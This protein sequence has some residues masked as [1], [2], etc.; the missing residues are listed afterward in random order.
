M[1]R[2]LLP[3]LLGRRVE[4]SPPVEEKAASL[5]QRQEPR[6]QILDVQDMTHARLLQLMGQL[7]RTDYT[8]GE[9]RRAAR[10]PLIAGIIRTILREVESH[11]LRVKEKDPTDD[12]TPKRMLE[13]VLASPNDVDRTF[14]VVI[15]GMMRDWLVVGRVPIE[16]LRSPKGQAYKVATRLMRGEID[17]ETFMQEVVKA[18][19]DPGPILG[20]IAHD[21]AVIRTNVS[22]S[23]V[24][25]DPAFY[26]VSRF[27][28][29]DFTVSEAKLKATG[30]QRWSPHEMVLIQYTG[31]T[32]R[33]RR[34]TS[35]SPTEECYPIIDTLY[36]MLVLLKDKVEKPQMDKLVSLVVPQDA[37]QLTSE[38]IDSIVAALREDLAQGTLPVLPYVE[39][40][41]SEIGMGES[42]RLLWGILKDLETI[43]WQIFGAGGVQM[44]RMEGQGRQAA[45][46]QMEAAKKQAVGN[47]LRIIADDFVS[48]VI[49]RD[50]WSPYQGLTV[51]WVDEASILSREERMEFM[52]KP[53]FEA[54][55]PVAAALEIDYP[56]I[57][58]Q[59]DALGIDWRNLQP[60]VLRAAMLKLGLVDL[61]GDEEEGVE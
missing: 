40:T 26:D 20:F 59:L 45:T 29:I 61:Q 13:R 30:V 15:D 60:P 17:H 27:G 44:L 31:T 58:A 48:V 55:V 33:D 5:E 22:S 23:G 38:Q 46:Q 2:R 51:E 1:L 12:D 37:R 39:A 3:G 52:W 24:L 36:G 7:R 34:F 47:M 49:L 43:A 56:W 32:E 21:P 10:L 28:G 18:V 4:K 41:V 50:A 35:P 14:R 25:R 11:K 8:I 6:G 54:G 9:L 42:F 57:T 16:L 19:R 53:L